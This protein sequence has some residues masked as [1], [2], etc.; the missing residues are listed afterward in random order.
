MHMDSFGAADTG[1]RRFGV[2]ERGNGRLKLRAGFMRDEKA[3]E[4]HRTPKRW[5]V[6]R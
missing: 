3:V 1:Q 5:R 6:D 4:G 2:D